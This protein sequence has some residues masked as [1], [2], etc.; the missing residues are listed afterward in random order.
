MLNYNSFNPTLDSSGAVTGFQADSGDYNADGSNNDYPNY[1]SAVNNSHSRD[2]F[3]NSGIFA[4]SSFTAPAVGSQGNEKRNIFRNPS[5][6]D[7]DASMLKNNRIFR[8]R[9][10]LQL[11]FDFFNV[12]NHVNLG[13]VDGSMFSSTFGKVTAVGDPRNIQL[14]ARISF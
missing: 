9:V 2:E 11:R 4:L 13:G 7:F 6:I 8:E 1:T 5:Y 3:L 12:L 14:G 10:N